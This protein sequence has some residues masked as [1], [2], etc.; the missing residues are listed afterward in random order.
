MLSSDFSLPPYGGIAAHVAGLSSALVARGHRVIVAFPLRRRR[1][2]EAPRRR[3]DSRASG[4]SPSPFSALRGENCRATPARPVFGH[5]AF[6]FDLIHVHDLLESAPLVPR[7]PS[8]G[9]HTYSPIT[10]RCSCDG[11]KCLLHAG[12]L[13]T[14]LGHP[15]G[16]IA[17]SP[18]LAVSSQL[19]HA[20]IVELIPSGVDTERFRPRPP[21]KEFQDASVSPLPA[22]SLWST[23]DGSTS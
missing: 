3:G 11:P 20:R 5:Y 12:L 19:L 18:D 4:L 15:D 9:A 7:A 14:L 22:I 8:T 10:L 21:D 6:D 16:I 2:L 17:V 13:P 1:R 23:S